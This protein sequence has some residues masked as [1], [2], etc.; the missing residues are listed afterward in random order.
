[1]CGCNEV[2]NMNKTLNLNDIGKM[3]IDEI[4]QAYKNGYTLSEL[5]PE[6]L[7]LPPYLRIRRR[8][9]RR[10]D[11]SYI[12]EI[13]SDIKETKLDNNEILSLV[14]C[15][16]PAIQGSTRNLLISVTSPGT[17]PYTFKLYKEGVLLDTYQ[18]IQIEASHPFSHLF[19]EPIGPYIFKGE[20]I[21]SCT[22]PGPKTVS[23]ECTVNV[24]APIP[25]QAGMGWILGLGLA[26]GFVFVATKK[27]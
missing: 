14:S 3:S 13:G 8:T 4:Q 9:F 23:N 18:G 19:S 1:M 24:Q 10:A 17:P 16:G 6:A 5:S 11:G 2:A 27:K 20:I 25:T 12:E 7:Q 22:S 15:D 26:L 21:D